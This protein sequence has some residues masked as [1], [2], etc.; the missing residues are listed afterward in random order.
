VGL[1]GGCRPRALN[2]YHPNMTTKNTSNS[3]RQVSLNNQDSQ[4]DGYVRWFVVHVTDESKPIGRLSP[5][6]IDK[7]LKAAAGDLKTVTRLQK[8]DILLE[9][10]TSTQSRC[11]SHL[12]DIVGCPVSVTPHRTLNS[13]KGVIRCRDLVD[14]DKAE[15]LSELNNQHLTD[16]NNITVRGDSGSRRNTNTF[17]VTFN[18]PSVPKHLKIGF[19]RVSVSVYIPNPLRCFNCQKFG[20]GSRTCKGATTCATCGQVG[21][22]ATEC[23]NNPKCVNCAGAHS[24]SSKECPKWVVEK[25]VQAVKAERGISF[26]EA[27]KIVTSENKAQP[28]SRGQSM[29]VVVRSSGGQQRPTTRSMHTQ[30]DL[31]WLEDKEAPTTISSTACSQSSQTETS[32]RTSPHACDV[33]F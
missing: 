11:L 17:I 22:G 27:R 5:F 32:G 28:I 18:L 10:S 20:H 9:A 29:A 23:H 21:H 33:R 26:I 8:G 3:S 24:A 30:T 12:K 4:S 16:I 14:C 6:L 15:I 2:I 13:C 19:I 25:K 7:A 31:T 1:R